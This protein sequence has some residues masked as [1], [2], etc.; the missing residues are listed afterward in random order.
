MVRKVFF[1]GFSRF[2]IDRVLR[3]GD[4]VP[5]SNF[6]AEGLDLLVDLLKMA[7]EMA[8][9]LKTYLKRLTFCR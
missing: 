4:P 9:S 8:E 6:I 1:F 2:Y 7:A 5:L 3:T